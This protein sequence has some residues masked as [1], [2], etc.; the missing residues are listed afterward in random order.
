MN[1]SLGQQMTEAADLVLAVPAERELPAGHLEERKQ[2]L[3][4]SVAGA[5]AEAGL[6]HRLRTVIGWL[7]SIA[8]VAAIAAAAVTLL[9]AGPRVSKQR[10]AELAVVTGAAAVVSVVSVVPR[11]AAVR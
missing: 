9:V 11:P 7:M 8:V 2:V 3:L 4:Q 5:P 6:R 10:V 1:E